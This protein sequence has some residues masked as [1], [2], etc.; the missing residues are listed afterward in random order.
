[1]E[2]N[3]MLTK[4]YACKKF[5]SEKIS[6]EQLSSLLEMVKLAP[7]SF[8]LQPFKVLVISDDETKEKLLSASFNQPQITTCSHLLVFCANKDVKER[9]D[10]YEQKMKDGGVPEEKVSAYIGMMRGFLEGLTDE[11][12]VAWAQRQ[13]YIALAN[14]LYGAKFLGFESCPMEGFN[15][16]DYSEILGLDDELVPTVLAPVGFPADEQPPKTRF[17]DEDLFIKK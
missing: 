1:M 17:S 7:S 6:D 12:K 13:I 11:H 3:E 9:I 15:P 5:N 10:S 2:F 16:Q 8:G 14:A 4:R